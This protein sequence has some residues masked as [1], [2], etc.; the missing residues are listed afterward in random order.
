MQKISYSSII[1]DFIEPLLPPEDTDEQFLMRMKIAEIIWNYCIAIEFK[2]PQYEK[3]V[4]EMNALNNQIPEMKPLVHLLTE[5]KKNEFYKYK[6]FITKLEVRTKADGL[7]TVYVESVEP[8]YL[9]KY[10]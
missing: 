4:K 7:K 8:K 2:L 6:N 5:R 9:K 1:Q 3:V 10:E